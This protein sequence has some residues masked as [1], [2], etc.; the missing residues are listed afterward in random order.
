LQS[1]DY[2]SEIRNV[3]SD[4]IYRKVTADPINKIERRTTALIKKS[5]ISE[6]DVKRLTPHVSAPP[7]LYGLPKIQKKDVPWR[8]IV[9]CI[10]S[11]NY[12][13]AKYLTGLLRPLVGQFDCH[14]R[15][16]EAFVQKLQ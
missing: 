15:K 5:E 13:L 6:E 16:S 4:P 3:L 12:A 9:N 8:P 2:R 7:R 14:I 10:G 11:P 1:E